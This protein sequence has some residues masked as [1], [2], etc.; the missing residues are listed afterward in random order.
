M[1][2]T[3]TSILALL[4]LFNCSNDSEDDLTDDTPITE[5]ITYNEHIKPIM[6][7]NC[8]NCH[9]NP[10]VNGAPMAL[11]TYETVKESMLNR[12]LFGRITTD[13]TALLM[14]VGGPKLPQNLIDQVEQWE[15]DGLLEE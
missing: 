7:N 2:L 1:K 8:I 4:L 15:T 10:P 9:S 3:Y 11:T 12:N 13:N 5:T 6:D 14:P